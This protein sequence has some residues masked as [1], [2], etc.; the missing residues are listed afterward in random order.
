MNSEKKT[1]PL[2]KRKL[3]EIIFEA[4]TFYGRLFDEILLVLIGV[5]ILL[6]T[7][8]SIPDLR[9]AYGIWFHYAE[10]AITLLFLAEYILRIACSPRPLQ[11]MKSFLGIIDLMAILPS[12]V[13]LLVPGIQALVVIRAI[14]ILRIY[15]I[16]KLYRYIKEGKMLMVALRA[17]FRKIFIFMIF[18]LILVII[19]GSLMYVVEGGQNGFYTIPN[20]IYWAIIT[21]TTVGYGDIV[22]V[23]GLGKFIASF[24]M[25]LGYS[26][27]AIPTGIVS[28]EMI[29]G[30][31]Q[32]EQVRQCEAC[33]DLGHEQKA[34]FC[35]NCGQQL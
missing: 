32:E 3:Y 21:L 23:S 18:V 22:P 13:A 19:L 7:L 5:S 16:L 29:R 10:W 31:N 34:L 35:K 4:E 26:I 6:V 12:F 17:S 27:I 1:L 11:Y 14:R 25:L 30:R 2:W 8:E 20:S 9:A 33:G 24:I 28:A 15:R